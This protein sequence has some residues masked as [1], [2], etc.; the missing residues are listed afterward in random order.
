MKDLE[1][2]TFYYIIMLHDEDYIPLVDYD[3]C[4]Y[5]A[6]HNEFE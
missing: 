5:L 4:N 2:G 3:I 1:V 6:P